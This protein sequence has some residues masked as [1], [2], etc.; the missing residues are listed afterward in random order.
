MIIKTYHGGNKKLNKIKPGIFTTTSIKGSL[1]YIHRVLNINKIAYLTKFK[2][3]Y[4]NP[5]TINNINDFVTKWEPI[6]KNTNIKY[7]FNKYSDNSWSFESNDIL[8][9]GGYVEN[10]VFDLIYIKEFI[11]ETI[12][13]GYDII[14]GYD[15]LE[16][17]DIPVY[18]PLN[19]N[20][21]K[22]L[23]NIKF[24]I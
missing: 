17:Y 3:R 15:T 8:K 14:I 18:I 6:L 20:N 13:Q 19:I 16:N 12:K 1:W 2:I 11:E 23:K 7:N 5:L 9:N 21:I 22:I 4:N 24:Y 10:N